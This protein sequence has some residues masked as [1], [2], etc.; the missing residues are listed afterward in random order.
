M[1]ERQANVILPYPHFRATERHMRIRREQMEA[2]HT[3]ALAAFEDEM[4]VHS[5]E[6]SPRLCE[7]IGEEQLR[8]ALRAA[9]DQA[10]GYGFTNRG[11]VRL[12]I[13]MR[14]LFGSAFDTDPQ[15]PWAAK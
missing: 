10:G 9:M 3:V 15:Y 6:F 8:V 5:K 14:F 4:V 1:E 13:E 11:P 2:F 7:V 12:F